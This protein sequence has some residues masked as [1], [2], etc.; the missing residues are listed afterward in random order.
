VTL[1][2][3]FSIK[4][5]IEGHGALPNLAQNIADRFTVI[6]TFPS[7][8]SFTAITLWCKIMNEVFNRE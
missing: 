2:E 4:G 6:M 1:S 7:A 5:A 8:M 3:N